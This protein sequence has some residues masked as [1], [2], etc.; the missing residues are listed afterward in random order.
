MS[1][2]P[3][4]FVVITLICGT[5]LGWTGALILGQFRAAPQAEESHTIAT[6][7]APPSNTNQSTTLTPDS[8][9]GDMVSS[10]SVA[11]PEPTVSQIAVSVSGAVRRPGVYTFNE[12]ER[13]K[14]GIRAA[15]GATE[16][17]DLSDIN[18]A[19]RLKDNTSLYIPFQMFRHQEGQSLVARRTQTATESNPARYTRSGWAQTTHQTTIAQQETTQDSTKQQAISPAAT[20]S[21]GLINLNTATLEE[22]Q[23]LPGIGPK[24]AEKIDAYRKGQPFQ[25]IE[26]LEAVSGIGPKTMESVRDLITVN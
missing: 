15:G 8:S 4:F 16:E 20:T 7:P 11:S 12:G 6:S 24:T 22:L 18:I 17:A 9:T 23:K 19:A 5:A 3:L 10:V 2:S 13:V 25:T 26:Q 1:R 14:H 21:S